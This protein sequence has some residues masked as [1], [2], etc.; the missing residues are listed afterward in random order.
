MFSYFQLGLDP[1]YITTMPTELISGLFFIKSTS[2]PP[3]MIHYL[4]YYS[5]HKIYIL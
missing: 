1:E 5:L 2:S 4:K 3:E